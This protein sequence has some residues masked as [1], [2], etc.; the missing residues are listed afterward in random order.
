MASEEHKTISLAEFIERSEKGEAVEQRLEDGTT[1]ELRVFTPAQADLL[2]VHRIFG[3]MV[4]GKAERES[5][6]PDDTAASIFSLGIGCLQACVKDE[7]GNGLPD[8]AA[9]DLFSRLPYQSPLLT[10]CQELCGV[11]VVTIPTLDLRKVVD[12][13]NAEQSSE[14]ERRT[15]KS[16]SGDE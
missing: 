10:K 6:I 1:I 3:R 5:D 9:V 14:K 15:A 8:V 13:G 12:A 2:E 4:G 11:G 16:G 7:H